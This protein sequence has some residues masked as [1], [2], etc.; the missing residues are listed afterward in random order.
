MYECVVCGGGDGMRLRL[1]VCGWG[2]GGEGKRV[3][4]IDGESKGC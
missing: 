2:L 3:S 1:L 4:E